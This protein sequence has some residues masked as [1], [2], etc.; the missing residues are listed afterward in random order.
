[1]PADAGGLFLDGE[2]FNAALAASLSHT[3][4]LRVRI[5]LPQGRG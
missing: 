4:E 2:A 3:Y 1:V 5:P